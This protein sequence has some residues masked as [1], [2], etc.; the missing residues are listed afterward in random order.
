MIDSTGNNIL[1]TYQF[2][3]SGVDYLLGLDIDTSGTIYACGSTQGTLDGQ[4]S[5]GEYDAYLIKL[6]VAN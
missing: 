4:V 3:S 5:L 2:G 6:S 1:W